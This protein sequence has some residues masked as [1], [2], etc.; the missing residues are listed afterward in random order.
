MPAP[1]LTVVAGGGGALGSAICRKLL[2]RGHAVRAGVR[3][4][5][6]RARREE[7]ER[8]GASLVDLELRRH[9]DLERELAGADVVVSTATCFPRANAI[10]AVDR[11]GTIALVDAAEKA[12]A[13]RFVFISFKPVPLDFPLQ[14]AKRAV[15]ERLRD[16]ALEAVVLRPSKFMDVWFS[17]IC[18]FDVAAGRAVVFGDG[19]APVSW[20]AADD[21]AEIAGRAALGEVEAGTIELGGPEALSQRDAIAVYED[22]LQRPFVLDYLPA[23]ELERRRAEAADPVAE[24]LAALMLEAARGSVTPMAERA[25]ALGVELTPLRRFAA[26]AAAS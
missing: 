21:V 10:D 5:T 12:G 20:I 11:D 4:S 6:P 14:R 25:E 22:V 24:S 7:L 23:D 18:G 2:A 19:T 8:L 9:A 26:A 17:P 1:A 13:A 3:A 15:E 16:A